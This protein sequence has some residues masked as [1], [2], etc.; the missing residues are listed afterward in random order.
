MILNVGKKK[1]TIKYGYKAVAKSGIIKKA[2]AIEN[3]ADNDDYGEMIET[4]LSVV[5]DM[6]LAGLQKTESSYSVDYDNKDD[7]RGKTEKVFDLLDD[8]IAQEESLT[9]PELFQELM[10]E[11][12]DAGF[13]GKKSERMEQIAQKTD[14]TIIPMDH[15][16]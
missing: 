12:F 6:V 1:Y 10:S 8:Y 9:I 13:F 15:K 11:M 3:I 16:S 5:A 2:L 14:A 4:M 7:V